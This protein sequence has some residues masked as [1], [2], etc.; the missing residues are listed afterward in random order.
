LLDKDDA[1]GGVVLNLDEYVKQGENITLALESSATLTVQKTTPIKFKL[2][3]KYVTNVFSLHLYNVAN[4]NNNMCAIMGQRMRELNLNSF[5]TLVFTILIPN[6]IL[7]YVF[8]ICAFYMQLSRL[9]H[10]WVQD[11]L[12]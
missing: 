1:I 9:Q 2:S 12:I 11:C 5:T 6:K 7:L 4:Y 3:V 8:N 10:R